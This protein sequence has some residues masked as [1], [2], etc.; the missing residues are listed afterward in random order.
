MANRNFLVLRLPGPIHWYDLGFPGLYPEL[1]NTRAETGWHQVVSKRA[2]PLR[3]HGT[4]RD[5]KE[6]RGLKPVISFVA[7]ARESCSSQGEASFIFS[8]AGV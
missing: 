4:A 8:A 3:C 5:L 2:N 1:Q 6:A 7:L